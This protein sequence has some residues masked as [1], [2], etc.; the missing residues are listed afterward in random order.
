MKSTKIK[1]RI[2]NRFGKCVLRNNRIDVRA[3]SKIAFSSQKNLSALNSIIHPVV[4]KVIDKKI[5]KLKQSGK[6]II[7]LDVPLLFESKMNKICDYIVCVNTKKNIRMK[8]LK[9]NKGLSQE[10]VRRRESFQTPIKKKMHFADFI[11][12]NS[13]TVKNTEKQ[14]N[15]VF[16][17]FKM[18]HS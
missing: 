9:R 13:S 1:Y 5:K 7:V 17:Q 15:E 2:T 11:I 12:D 14:I 18:L 6:K 16:K 8:R 10:E 3:L 4:R